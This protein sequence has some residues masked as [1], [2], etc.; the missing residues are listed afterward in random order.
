MGNSLLFSG[1]ELIILGLRHNIIVLGQ[2]FSLILL[3]SIKFR[4]KLFKIIMNSHWN[5]QILQEVEEKSELERTEALNQKMLQNILPH[6]IAQSFFAKSELYY[7][8]CH[9]GGVIYISVCSFLSSNF[10]D[11][12][13]FSIWKSVSFSTRLSVSN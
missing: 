10:S 3:S 4:H 6:H 11:Q 12:M 9:S 13:Q 8:L 1:K 2:L 5:W 7:H